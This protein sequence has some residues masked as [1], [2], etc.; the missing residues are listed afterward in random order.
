MIGL[1]QLLSKFIW[2]INFLR[3]ICQDKSLDNIIVF[4]FEGV[5]TNMLLV[6]QHALFRITESKGLSTDDDGR[7]QGLRGAAKV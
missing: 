3:G 1:Q 7:V 2:N 4:G 5:K 6:I